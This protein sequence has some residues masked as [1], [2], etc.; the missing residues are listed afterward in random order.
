MERVCRDR[1]EIVET[2]LV[3]GKEGHNYIPKW[4]FA[5]MEKEVDEEENVETF[6]MDEED[7]ETKDY[8]ESKADKDEEAVD[9]K[10]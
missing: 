2:I 6:E 4:V 3:G 9:A 10:R 7:L 5:V 1:K 8:D